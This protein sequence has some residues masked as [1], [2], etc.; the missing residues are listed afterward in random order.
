VKNATEE[1]ESHYKESN[2]EFYAGVIGKLIG[3]VRSS[4]VN[5][6]DDV[7][8]RNQ[9]FRDR[10]QRVEAQR[11]KAEELNNSIGIIM[12]HLSRNSTDSADATSDETVK[13]KR[14][15]RFME[16]EVGERDEIPIKLNALDSD[17][18][19]EDA[20][21]ANDYELITPQDDN[22]FSKYYHYIKQ[23]HRINRAKKIQKFLKLI[24]T[25]VLLLNETTSMEMTFDII[26]NNERIAQ[27]TPLDIVRI[28]HRESNSDTFQ[29]RLKSILK[30]IVY[31]YTRLYL[32]ARR[33][34]KKSHFPAAQRD[35]YKILNSISEDENEI[36]DDDDDDDVDLIGMNEDDDFEFT[37]NDGRSVKSVESLAILLLEIFGALYALGIGFWAHLENGFF[38]ELLE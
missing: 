12:K 11:M 26:H 8:M 27:L 2:A 18:L 14:N 19:N 15:D 31:K 30:R 33:N 5:L 16:D 4:F 9:H 35:D 6:Y 32:I 29:T 36:S 21:V 34:F 25:P 22:W 23:Q 13:R 10:S 28:L 38:F 7:R 1:M 3:S 37:T 17:Y 24:L 20:T